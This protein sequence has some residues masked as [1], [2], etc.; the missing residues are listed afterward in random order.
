MLFIA[1]QLP[2]ALQVDEIV[3]LGPT[4]A[5]RRLRAVRRGGE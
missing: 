4:G 1:H 3:R 2:R 5:R